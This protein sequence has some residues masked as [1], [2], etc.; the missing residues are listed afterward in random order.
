MHDPDAEENTART[1]ALLNESCDELLGSC[2]D[3]VSWI[4]G[5]LGGVRTGRFRFW[6]REVEK[7]RIWQE[8]MDGIQKLRD[9]LV[10]VLEQFRNEKR[11]GSFGDH[12]LL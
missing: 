8:R 10:S 12:R 2:C 5:W 3:A 4:Q 9:G 7:D 11:Y 6:V 1:T